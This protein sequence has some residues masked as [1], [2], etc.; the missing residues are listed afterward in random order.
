MELFQADA[1]HIFDKQWALVTAGT[2]NHYNTMTISWGGLGTLWSRPV[3]TVYVKPIRYTY[4]FLEKNEYFTVSFFPEAYK[5][6]LGILGS[7]SGRDGDKI[8]L[9]S[10]T[11][12][13]VEHGVTFSQASATLIC[14]KIY[15]QDLDLE[16]IP[17]DA[18]DAYYQTEAPNR[19][20][21]GEV[22]DILYGNES[23]NASL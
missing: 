18:V 16:Q 7:K 17:Q 9:T 20:Y 14:K 4:Q 6:D 3:A 5:K 19:M 21:I 10:L 13:P 23:D 15:W 12:Q 2:L 22:I 8:S 1:F 11:P